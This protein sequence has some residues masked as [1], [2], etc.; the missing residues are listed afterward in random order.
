MS[1]TGTP[2]KTKG[3]APANKDPL[4]RKITFQISIFV[5]NPFLFSG[6][7][8]MFLLFFFVLFKDDPSY[9][10]NSTL[11]KMLVHP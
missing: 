10:S 5:S 11:W 9:D 8:W 7:N 3:L 4:K 2:L 6:V 1:D